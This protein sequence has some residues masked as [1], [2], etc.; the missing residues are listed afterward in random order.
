M[1]NEKMET[2]ILKYENTIGFLNI[3]YILKWCVIDNYKS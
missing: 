2:R 3:F 1:F